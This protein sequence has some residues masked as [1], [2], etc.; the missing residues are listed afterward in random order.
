MLT[1][2]LHGL[3]VTAAGAIVPFGLVLARMAGL[4]SLLDRT[5]T[6]RQDLEHLVRHD[7]LTGLANRLLPTGRLALAED[8][9]RS[10]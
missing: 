7:P 3:V 4:V 8:F 1:D 9:G 10:S 5:L 2:H 6:S